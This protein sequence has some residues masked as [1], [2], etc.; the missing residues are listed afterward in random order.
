MVQDSQA[1]NEIVF[2]VFCSE[3]SV[4]DAA[5]NWIRW[6]VC[7]CI[8]HIGFWAGSSTPVKR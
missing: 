1:H 6:V 5:V 4:N 8:L 3:F 7:P 2:L